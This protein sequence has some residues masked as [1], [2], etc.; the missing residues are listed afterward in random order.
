[1]LFRFAPP[2]SPDEE[3][4]ALKAEARADAGARAPA[5][6]RRFMQMHLGTLVG[7]VVGAA[8]AP[9][10]MFACSVTA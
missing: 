4:I 2:A 3:G 6:C 9:L 5:R 7:L 1:M 8:V 10:C